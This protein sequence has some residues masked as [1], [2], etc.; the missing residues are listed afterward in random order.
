GNG[1]NRD[2]SIPTV[3][4]GLSDAISLALGDSHTCVV[5]SDQTAECWGDNSRGQLGRGDTNNSPTPVPVMN[6]T[7][8]KELVTGGFQTCARTAKGALLC[9]GGANGLTSPTPVPLTCP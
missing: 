1:S 2:S 8:I 5:R 6:L 9:W 7:D 3:V 4:P